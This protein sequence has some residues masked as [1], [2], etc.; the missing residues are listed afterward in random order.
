[1]QGAAGTLIGDVLTLQTVPLSSAAAWQEEA[2]LGVKAGLPEAAELSEAE[3]F[4]LAMA[5]Y[6]LRGSRIVHEPSPDTK[7]G[8]PFLLSPAPVLHGAPGV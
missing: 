3:H 5:I 7:V 8:F 6:D 4:R 1:M 2:E